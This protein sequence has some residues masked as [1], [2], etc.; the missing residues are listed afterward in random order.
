MMLRPQET[1]SI[2]RLITDHTDE[3]TYYVRAVIRNSRTGATLATVNLT[4]EGNRRF[5]GTWQTPE[6]TNDYLFIDVTTTVYTDSNY[7][8]KSGNYGEEVKTLMIEQRPKQSAGGAGIVTVDYAKIQK[9]VEKAVS[10]IEIPEQPEMPEMPEY[11]DA[12]VVEM[13]ENMQTMLVELVSGI[14][15]PDMKSVE[16][17]VK[18][19]Q[20]SLEA[21]LDALELPVPNI[22]MGPVLEA[23]KRS[24]IPQ[25]LE[26][27]DNA[28]TVL[29]DV[30]EK[31]PSLGEK[32]ESVREAMK[33]IAL[34][35]SESKNIA[36]G[37]KEGLREYSFAT[38]GQK[39]PQE[40]Q[41]SK[42]DVRAALADRARNLRS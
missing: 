27:F 34:E 21:K 29:A 8:T 31:V 23:F 3:N 39:Q 28:A 41:P 18:A 5:T 11:D 13:V 19:T 6:I 9:M 22:E 24:G 26:D 32:I 36:S 42:R 7:T 1:F 30:A 4:D 2:V 12:R 40:Q 17:L 33:D 14:E 20:L 25:M 38:V 10:S 35:L 15:M 16:T 37:I